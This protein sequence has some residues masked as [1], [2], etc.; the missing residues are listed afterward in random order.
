MKKFA[1]LAS[2][3]LGDLDKH[4]KRMILTLSAIAWG[5]LSILLLL[6]FGEG[7]KRQMGKS[8]KGLGINIVI[9]YGGQTSKVFQGLPKGRRIRFTIEDAQLLKERIPE[10]VNISPEFDFWGASFTYKEKTLTERFTGT[11]PSFEDM[12]THYPDM[13]G[14]FINDADVRK[15]RRV[16]FL[17]HDLAERLFEEEDPIGKE[18]SINNIPF[19]VIGVMIDKLQ[20]SMY[21][22]PD[23][24]KGVIPFTTLKSIFGRHYVDR[25]VYQVSDPDMAPKVE[26]LV[27][28][29]LG[30]KYKFDQEDSQAI[31][32][33]DVVKQNKVTN[34]IMS[35]IQ[36]FLGLI[37]TLTLLIASVGVANTMYVA[38]K[39]RTREI[40]VKRALG[41][42]RSHI[43]TQFILEAGLISV[44]GGLIG[45][46]IAA[47]II[48]ILQSLPTAE[49]PLQFLGRPT[50]SLSIAISTG[51][52]LGIISL[53]AG[54]F[55]ARKA[56]KI[57]P[58]EALRYE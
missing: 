21:G 14:R 12:R 32:V 2:L 57:S 18:I 5:T 24:N 45:T 40:G 29:F 38:V 43:R 51:T 49:G 27:W 9:L 39:E 6:S 4:R 30:A 1:A 22:G 52:I 44:I 56:A 16:I 28:R 55:P 36:I 34:T 48:Q 46:M 26:R 13:G 8:G 33:W 15:R 20:M 17:G 11:G 25:L 47:G 58:V 7:L 50:F 53:A 23:T 42:K 10:I 19:T 35:G 37:G 3:F 41:A 54:Y 31:A